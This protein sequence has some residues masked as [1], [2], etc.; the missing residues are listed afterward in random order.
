M[1]TRVALVLLV[2]ASGAA[3]ACSDDG[4]RTTDAPDASV[5]AWCEAF[6]ETTATDLDPE[7]NLAFDRLVDVAPGEIREASEVLRDFS[8]GETSGDQADLAQADGDVRAY[9]G[10]HCN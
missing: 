1:R 7:D 6:E 5:E 10:A 8:L 4:D 9:A 3:G 2:V